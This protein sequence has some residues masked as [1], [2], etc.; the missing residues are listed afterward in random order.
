M[1]SRL[2]VKIVRNVPVSTYP[3]TDYFKGFEKVEAVRRIFGERTRKV[4][5]NLKVEFAWTRGYMGVNDTDG[6]LL[7]S[8]R[9]MK[10]GD[11]IDIYLDII[12]ELAHVKQFMDG[13]KLFDDNFSYT[14]RPTEVEAYR[15]A[16]EEARNLGL[17]DERICEYLKTEWMSDEDLKRLAETLNV[18]CIHVK[19]EAKES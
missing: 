19:D 18:K 15:Y 8:A 1:D 14:E 4:L 5:G 11:I 3:F 7:I 12:H 6:H 17:S 9:Y 13:K 16:V 10:E 2:M